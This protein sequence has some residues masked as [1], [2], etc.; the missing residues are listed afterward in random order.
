MRYSPDTALELQEPSFAHCIAG[1]LGISIDQLSLTYM[2]DM[3]LTSVKHSERAHQETTYLFKFYYV[4][5]HADEPKETAL[6]TKHFELGG[7]EFSWLTVGEMDSHVST[8]KRNQDVINHLTIHYDL[9]FS[10]APNALKQLI[11][12]DPGH[13]VP[14]PRAKN[15]RSLSGKK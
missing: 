6:T 9:F 5:I 4:S 3:D 15:D 2:E 13:I 12:P 10:K 1:Y 11:N 8:F 14:T 7:K